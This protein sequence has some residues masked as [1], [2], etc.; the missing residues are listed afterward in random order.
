MYESHHSALVEVLDCPNTKPDKETALLLAA[1]QPFTGPLAA[2]G[3]QGGPTPG[4]PE[5]QPG[6]QDGEEAT[7]APT[8][9]PTDRLASLLDAIDSMIDV[10]SRV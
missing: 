8:L 6:P 9:V 2:G 7:A 5:G 3:P 1:V 10:S 4:A